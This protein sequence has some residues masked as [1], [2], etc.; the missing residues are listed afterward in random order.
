MDFFWS[1][2][3]NKC[4]QVSRTL[5]SILADLINA[6]DMDGLGTSSDFPLFQFFNEDFGDGSK[7]IIYNWYLR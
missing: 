7:H 3:E 5:L 1:L 2:S 4:P 6:V